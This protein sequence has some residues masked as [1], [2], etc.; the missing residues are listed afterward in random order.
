M[1]LGLLVSVV[2]DLQV[3]YV[4]F[5]TELVKGKQEVVSID[6]LSITALAP[7]AGL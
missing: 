3:A 7:I 4:V 6:S 2:V 1:L 5:K